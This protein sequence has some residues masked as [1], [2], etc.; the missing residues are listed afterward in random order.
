[1]GI[2]VQQLGSIIPIKNNVPFY[3]S[4]GIGSVAAIAATV[5]VIQLIAQNKDKIKEFWS[6]LKSINNTDN[7]TPFP[8]G[9]IPF[10]KYMYGQP[11]FGKPPLAEPTNIAF[12]RSWEEATK[13]EWQ[14]AGVPDMATAIALFM[15]YGT[16]V[17]AERNYSNGS[18]FWVEVMKKYNADLNLA[19]TQ[20]QD[21]TDPSSSNTQMAGMGIF[22]FLLLLLI[23]IGSKL[24]SKPTPTTKTEEK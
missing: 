11:N 13:P 4:S 7:T 18:Q 10:W 21:Y 8:P 12:A 23:A 15:Q 22:G 16:Q 2:P 1:M 19:N 6:A 9:Y 5:K 17:A 24:K 14:P 20:V 3:G